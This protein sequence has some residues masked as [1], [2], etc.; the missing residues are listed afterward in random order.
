MA[1][2]EQL[3]RRILSMTQTTDKKD[4]K[5]ANGASDRTISR[6]GGTLEM[7]PCGDQSQALFWDCR[8]PDP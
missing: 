2:S 5:E 8:V 3:W 6:M 1:G 7:A 4:Q